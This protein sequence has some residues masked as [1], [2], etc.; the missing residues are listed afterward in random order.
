MVTGNDIAD[1]IKQYYIEN[2]SE[3]YPKDVTINMFT[4]T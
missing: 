3:I 1:L 2:Y 4:A